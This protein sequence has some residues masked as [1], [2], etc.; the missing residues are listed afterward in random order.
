MIELKGKTWENC[1]TP[2][3]EADKEMQ[4]PRHPKFE[5]MTVSD[6]EQWVQWLK[7]CA[8]LNK[9]DPDTLPVVVQVDGTE[10]LFKGF[11][12]GSHVNSSDMYGFAMAHDFDKIIDK[13]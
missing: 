5:T 1:T 7:N 11:G 3:I 4:E 6:L 9:L 8:K 10:Y 13:E 2:A 12:F